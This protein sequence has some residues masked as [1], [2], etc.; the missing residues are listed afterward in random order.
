M[1]WSLFRLLIAVVVAASMAA[2]AMPAAAQDTQTAAAAAQTPA[3]PA[4]PAAPAAPAGRLADTS[5]SLFA[6][7]W[8]VL[9]LS[10]RLASTSGDPARW[11]R[12]Q[13]LRD[14]LLFTGARFQRETPD[15]NVTAGAD[16]LGWRD[17][18][19]TG[20]YE[21]VGKFRISGFWD[22]IPQFYSVDTRTAYATR[23][24]E[25][26]LTLDDA[27]QQSIQ[28]QAATLTAY[29]SISPQFN[30]IEGRDI[31]TVR[32]TVTPTP[33]W[34]VTGG[35]TTTGHSGEL[36]WG[37]SFGFSNNAEVALP[38]RSRT[39]DMDVGAQWTNT[40]SM[41]RAGYTSSWFNNQNDTLTWDSPLRLT[42]GVELPGRGRTALWPTNSLQTLSA[43]GYTKFARR[44]QLTGSLSFGW[45]NNDSALL[46]F[47]INSALPQ[48]ALP[49]PTAEAAANTV[50][51]NLNLVSRPLEDWR[52]SARFRRYDYA[53]ETP[54]AAIPEYVS[55]DS[56]VSTSLTGGPRLFAHNRNT[57]D[58]EA[59][60]TRLNP[61]VLSLGYTNNHNGYDER[62]F[63]STNENAIHLKADAVAFQALTFRAHYEYGS[64]SGSG[65]NEESLEQIGEYAE[66]R[67][68]D[69][70]NRT[71]NR[72]VGQ[73][74]MTPIEPLTLSFSAGLGTDDFDES[75]F[76]LQEA[77]FRNITF[78]IDYE[79]PNGFVFGGTYNYE[80][81]SGF[82]KSRSA[83]PGEQQ[84]DP[85]RDWT[86]DSVER[87]DYFSIYVHPPRFGR[88][89]T[90]VSYDY[91]H[92]RSDFV[93]EVGSALAPPSQLPQTFNKMQ[94]FKLDVR[95]RLT[96]QIAATFSYVY[97]PLRIYDFAFDPSVINGIVQP[98]SLVLGYTY[99]PY[100]AHSAVVGI[101]YY[102]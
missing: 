37:G 18:R 87:V 30:L 85:N 2:R 26:I 47:T 52:L 42:D 55:Y 10:G 56:E 41:F 68:Y 82:Q 65:L 83:S 53:N 67:H 66:M 73:V 48:L 13:D 36:P 35:F 34:D 29:E 89:E 88:T 8:N 6:P 79:T 49:R 21:R 97:E 50:S 58:A 71:R 102:W 1:R 60:W 81:Y 61:V 64:R 74:D 38:Y 101:L 7:T 19:Y 3:P 27:V 92:A 57:L 12:Y 44:T 32:A 11:Q 93:Y 75:T 69:L 46:P 17:Q 4:P 76:G 39:N 78:G 94:D 23:P 15:W 33:H 63:D 43:A 77:A 80:R 5:T 45:W 84:L 54:A 98:S 100:T 22:E 91:A 95:H 72:F 9:Q 96:G 51:T 24:E 59:T 86:V 40:R 99:R 70:A 31:G 62:T 25:G 90:R 28:N 20:S 16:N 14:G